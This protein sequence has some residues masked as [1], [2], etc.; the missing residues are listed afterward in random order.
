MKLLQY[1][2]PSLPL[3][4]PLHSSICSGMGDASYRLLLWNKIKGKEMG[5]HRNGYLQNNQ[6]V[7]G[8]DDHVT[9]C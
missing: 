9:S 1:P 8:Q 3:L 6:S 4:S 2:I 5:T 7:P